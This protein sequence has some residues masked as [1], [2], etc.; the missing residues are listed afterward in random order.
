MMAVQAGK[1]SGVS[2]VPNELCG[3]TLQHMLAFP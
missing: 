2:A 3:E 1:T